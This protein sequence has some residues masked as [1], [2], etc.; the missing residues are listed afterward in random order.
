MEKFNLKNKNKEVSHKKP[1]GIRKF[2]VPALIALS[3]FLP[4]KESYSQNNDQLNKTNNTEW[5]L[6]M[7]QAGRSGNFLPEKTWH[8]LDKN[9]SEATNESKTYPGFVEYYIKDSNGKYIFFQY[10]D[11]NG[12]IINTPDFIRSE[13]EI[14]KENSIEYLNPEEWAKKQFEYQKTEEFK[15]EVLNKRL[16]LLNSKIKDIKDKIELSKDLS[17]Y[18]GS[19]EESTDLKD[20]KLLEEALEHDKSDFQWIIDK[21]T[22]TESELLEIA[23]KNFDF[24]NN[25]IINYQQELDKVLDYIKSNTK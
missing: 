12:D 3:T 1:S 22:K 13:I 15:N 18:R 8:F 11:K 19:K 24:Y 23:I 7:G 10:N 16:N 9:M 4:S 14:E 6:K 17:S 20:L 21:E 25:K 2:T 5:Q